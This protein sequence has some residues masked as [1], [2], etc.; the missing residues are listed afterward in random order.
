MK[1]ILP[2]LF[3]VGL[4]VKALAAIGGGPGGSFIQN[5][6]TLQSNATFYV[7]SGTVKN[8]NVSTITFSDGSRQTTAAISGS[9][10][11]TLQTKV[12]GVQVSSP[13]K[14]LSFDSDFTGIESPIGTANISFATGVA[15]TNRDETF[16]SPKTFSSSDTFTNRV[17][18]RSSSFNVVTIGFTTTTAQSPSYNGVYIDAS[19]NL[20]IAANAYFDGTNW[21]R[22]D[23]TKYSFALELLG[24][25]FVAGE[26]NQGSVLWRCVPGANPIGSF[27]TV[28]GWE[29][30]LESVQTKDLEVGGN[31]TEVHGNGVSPYGR[32]IHSLVGTSTHTGVAQNVYADFSGRDDPTKRAWF[33]GIKD[34]GFIVE[35]SSASGGPFNTWVSISSNGLLSG[36]TFQFS[37]G[38]VTGQLSASSI[39][40]PDGSILISSFSVLALT[41]ISSTTIGAT[42][43]FIL[44]G[45]GLQSGT[46]FYVSSG[47]V[48]E[49][50]NIN[51]FQRLTQTNN[52]FGNKAS[53][54]LDTFT[55]S[56]FAGDT[57][58]R[59]YIYVPRG[60]IAEGEFEMIVSTMPYN[61]FLPV[62]P[63][64]GDILLLLRP[65]DGSGTMNFSVQQGNSGPNLFNAAPSGGTFQIPVIIS[66]SGA[67]VTGLTVTGNIV[68]QDGLTVTSQPNRAISLTAGTMPADDS[69]TGAGVFINGGAGDDTVAGGSVTIHAGNAVNGTSDIFIAPGKNGTNGFGNVWVVTNNDLIIT[70]DTVN[71][72]RM[73]IN[74]PSLSVN[75]TLFVPNNGGTFTVAA[76]TGLTLTAGG[77]MQLSTP[78]TIGSGG[79]GASTIQSNALIFSN[80]LGT[81]Y[82]SDNANFSI[83]SINHTMGLQASAG[84]KNILTLGAPAATKAQIILT[85]G[86]YN[87]TPNS[88]DVWGDTAT[89]SV[90][91]GEAGMPVPVS[92]ATFVVTNSSTVSNTTNET[93]FLSGLGVTT[94]PVSVVKTGNTFEIKAW[95]FLDTAI[96]PGNPDIRV[97]IGTTTVLDTGSIAIAASLLSSAT[98]RLEGM[99]TVRSGTAAGSVMGNG[100]FDIFDNTNDSLLFSVPM[101]NI[102]N[103]TGINFTS[104]QAITATVQWNTAAAQNSLVCENGYILFHY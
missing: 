64:A 1:R 101:R 11:S 78:V 77:T 18:V 55:A 5:Q 17:E 69:A 43:Y 56:G 8:V 58:V 6:N 67:G 63:N 76:G 16:T 86:T 42:T 99:I 60:S 72:K 46:T 62:A 10:A 21:N 26:A 25:G 84:T 61:S 80:S 53:I 57:R 87:T 54:V 33:A 95:G 34:D 73:I 30:G 104:T 12:N 81:S 48:N 19:G 36:T 89:N 31:G 93:N 51:G 49:Q 71:G 20:W 94:I 7:S 28:G 37:S 83:D 66:T 88:G 13:T 75:R 74:F 103:T 35:R 23:V 4:S 38:T 29:L 39:K 45:N 102:T 79:T 92:G 24:Q 22:K 97:K 9:G 2:F 27:L 100:R 41:S 3:G 90:M 96:T 59:K 14:T 40:F 50:L 15:H 98:W 82:T 44:N 47:T 68:G 85:E 32:F 91:F 65:D 70:S 52:T